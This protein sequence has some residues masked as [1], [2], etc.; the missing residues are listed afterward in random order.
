MFDNEIY[1]KTMMFTGAASRDVSASIEKFKLS[2][3]FT[4]IMQHCK[5]IQISAMYN[6]SNDTY[7]YSVSALIKPSDLT[8]YRLKFS[9]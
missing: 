7:S 8:F 6:M 3:Q 5:K 4:W 9:I 2:E 1:T